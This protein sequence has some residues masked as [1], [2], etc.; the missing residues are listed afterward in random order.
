MTAGRGKG[1]EK[2]G[3]VLWEPVRFGQQPPVECLQ[4]VTFTL[5]GLA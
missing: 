3:Q 4:E 2:N 1:D 5:S